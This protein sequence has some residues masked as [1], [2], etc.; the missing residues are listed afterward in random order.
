MGSGEGVERELRERQ[1]A[2]VAGELCHASGQGMRGFGVPQ[3]E[4]ELGAC[5]GDPEPAADS[6]GTDVESENQLECSGHCRGGRCVALRQSHG[7]RVQDSVDRTRR[8]GTG[9]RSA[10]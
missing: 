9:G 1:R 2:H 3:L 5:P 8:F 10:R 4:G 6:V 7:E